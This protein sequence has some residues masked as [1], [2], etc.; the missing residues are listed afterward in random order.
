MYT[1]SIP[2]PSHLSII[3]NLLQPITTKNYNY[4]LISPICCRP[5]S[6]FTVG[7][8]QPAMLDKK[9][10]SIHN[11][12]NFCVITWLHTINTFL[13]SL[14]PVQYFIYPPGQWSSGPLAL[15]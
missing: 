5:P 13:Q 11:Y 1:C 8:T 3:S 6:G 7:K 4:S 10:Q 12:R 2:Y 14:G 15:T 9:G